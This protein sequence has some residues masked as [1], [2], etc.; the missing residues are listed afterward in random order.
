MRLLIQ[1]AARVARTILSVHVVQGTDD[2]KLY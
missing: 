1:G 2:S